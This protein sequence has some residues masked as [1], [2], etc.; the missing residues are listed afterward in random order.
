MKR[1]DVRQIGL[2]LAASLGLAACGD[3]EVILEGERL[4]IA[5]EAREAVVNRAVPLSLPRASRNGDWTQVGGNAQHHLSHLALASSLSPVWSVSLGEGNGRKHRMTAD[6]VVG[7][8]RVYA[9]DSGANLRAFTTGGAALWSA[10]LTPASDNANEASGGGLALGGGAV[11]ATTGFGEVTALSAAS[12]EPRWVQKLESAATGAPTYHDGV[13]YLVTRNNIGWALDAQS[14]RI[15]WQVLGADSRNGVAG[16]AAPSIAGEQVIFPLSSGQLVGAVHGVGSRTW[17]ASIAGERRGRAFS[18]FSDLTGE[19]VVAN[20]VVYAGNHSGRA[21]AFS[22]VDGQR[23]WRADEGALSP[24]WVAGGSVFLVSDEN[25][26]IRLDAATGDTIWAVDLPFFEK[27]KIARRESTVS[28]YGPVMAGGQLV[29]VSNDGLLRRFDPV[30]GALTGTV[31]LP[32]GA[33]R[34]PVIANGTLYI[35]TENGQLHAFR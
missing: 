4:D 19:P 18:R 31:D 20:G 21:A 15:L 5:G 34:N 13:V 33:A 12:G 17:L 2:V 6:P 11:F 32:Q 16:G 22:A 28:H 23:I 27:S 10:D 8:G 25:R 7:G 24:V 9:M 3:R 30:S 35:V 26:L 14:G 1:R 29:L